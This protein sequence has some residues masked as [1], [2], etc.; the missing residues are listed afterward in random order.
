VGCQPSIII[1]LQQRLGEPSSAPLTA[2]AC[3]T[4]GLMLMLL[5]G[6]EWLQ[7]C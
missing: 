7:A 4:V 6:V 1:I 2:A 3:S 5:L